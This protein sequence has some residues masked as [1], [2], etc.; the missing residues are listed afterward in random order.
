MPRINWQMLWLAPWLLATLGGSTDSALAPPMP[1]P[2]T[3]PTVPTDS[4]LL[5][6]TVRSV[7]PLP[8]LLPLRITILRQRQ[9]ASHTAYRPA[10]PPATGQRQR[11]LLST[12]LM[13]TKSLQQ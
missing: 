4:T 6:R 1:T 8:A 9:T 13:W 5:L 11:T 3:P 2:L 12:S 7:L 10:T